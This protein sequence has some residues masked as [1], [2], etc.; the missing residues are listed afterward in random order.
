[1]NL[2]AGSDDIMNDLK[3]PEVKMLESKLQ[4]MRELKK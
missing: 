2:D 3:S 1:M 4:F